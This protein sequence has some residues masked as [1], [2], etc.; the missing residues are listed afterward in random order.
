MIDE[1]PE[2]YVRV[3]QLLQPY[4]GLEKIQP[5]TLANAAERGKR[6]HAYCELYAQ[7]M[8]IE[9]V[10]DDCKGYVESFKRWIELVKPEI[11]SLEERIVNEQYKVTGKYDMIVKLPGSS[12]KILVDIKTPLSPNRTWPLQTAAYHWMLSSKG[13][14][15]ERRGCLMI[16]RYGKIASFREHNNSK[17][18][19][20]FLGILRAYRYVN[21]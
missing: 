5:E 7:S 17:D 6:A 3:T 14:P 21:P 12:D 8:L 9:E 19:E 2:G 1:I 15:V 16:D 11:L 4:N 18:A 10:S 13:N 20:I